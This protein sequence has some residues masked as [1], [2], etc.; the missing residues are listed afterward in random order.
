MTCWRRPRRL[1]GEN[2]VQVTS[3]FQ[4]RAA[5]VA[6]EPGETP[7]RRDTTEGIPIAVLT[8]RKARQGGGLGR[9]GQT[10][11][12]R[13]KACT[14][15]ASGRFWNRPGGARDDDEGCQRSVLCEV[16]AAPADEARAVR[17]SRCREAPP[18][19]CYVEGSWN[20]A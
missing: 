11:S 2:G 9:A 13:R 19:K 7:V 14:S 1:R 3:A 20:L 16:K 18:S 17:H 15:S 4:T 6:G 8:F 10:R 5:N 12:V